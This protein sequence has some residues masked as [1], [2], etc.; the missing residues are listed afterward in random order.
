VDRWEVLEVSDVAVVV[1]LRD[2]V[3]AEFVR[4]VE[5]V[6]V[7]VGVEVD[8]RGEGTFTQP[9]ALDRRMRLG[10]D[11][12]RGH[13]DNRVADGLLRVG[14]GYGF[15]PDLRKDDLCVAGA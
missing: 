12:A 9:A 14:Q 15:N 5:G 2:I 8:E 6:G 3:G 10:Q 4:F 1:E 11:R 7:P 13:Y